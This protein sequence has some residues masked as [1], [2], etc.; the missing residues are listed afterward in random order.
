[1]I[2]KLEKNNLLEVKRNGSGKAVEVKIKISKL[3]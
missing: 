3:N 1:V 2:C